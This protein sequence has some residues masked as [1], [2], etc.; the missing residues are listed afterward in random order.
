VGGDGEP[1]ATVVGVVRDYR[2]YQLPQPMRPAVYL[3]YATWPA[4]QEDLVIRTARGEASALVPALR[5]VVREL[6]P[7]VALFRVQTL[8]EAVSRSLWRQRLQGHVV[9]IFAVLALA[10]ACVGLY[11]VISYAVAQR[12][13]EL[14]VRMALGAT[15]GDVLRLVLA[16]SGQLVAAG[17]A[18]GLAA[19]WGSTRAMRSLLYGVE[20]TDPATFA[21]VP[22]CLA[23]VALLA[24]LAPA[25]RATRI[26]P[27]I[28][29]RA[30]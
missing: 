17:V 7:R 21:A 23:A 9:G 18:L 6:D 14:G 24:A 13:R 30:E 10:L 15:R 11:G 3:P 28:A 4:R 5:A 1:Y 16:Q 26:D 25:R 2:H 27:T 22:A 29:M 12:T 19:A 8:D 20:P